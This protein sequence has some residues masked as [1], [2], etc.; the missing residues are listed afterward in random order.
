MAFEDIIKKIKSDSQNEIKSMLAEIE[1]ETSNILSTNEARIK[2]LREDST[3]DAQLKAKIEADRAITLANIDFKKELLKTRQDKINSAFKD[4]GRMVAGLDDKE[5]SKFIMSIIRS[6]KLDGDEEVISNPTRLLLFK[7]GLVYEINKELGTN[8][9]LSD[10]TR[11]FSGGLF[12]KKGK[13]ETN[14]TLDAIIRSLREDLEPEVAKIL[15][16]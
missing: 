4:A 12:L 10:E 5:Y 8:L 6:V 2:K 9:V 7:N 3:R 16:K 14:L 13:I 15:F 1:D 11:N